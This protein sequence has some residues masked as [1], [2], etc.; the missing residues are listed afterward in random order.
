MPCFAVLKENMSTPKYNK[1]K[2]VPLNW[3][4]SFETFKNNISNKRNRILA[5]R[6]VQGKN[7]IM[8][9]D[10]KSLGSVCILYNLSFNETSKM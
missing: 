7:D 8:E 1:Y 3:W 2:T 4:P 5:H 10:E 9:K 6:A